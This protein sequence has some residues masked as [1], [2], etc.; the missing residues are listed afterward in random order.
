MK[1]RMKKEVKD[2]ETA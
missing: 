1:F 2:L